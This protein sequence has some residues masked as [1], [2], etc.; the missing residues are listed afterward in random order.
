MISEFD[1]K[2]PEFGK[3]FIA[4][5]AQII[6]QVKIGNESSVWFNAT[7]RA[8]LGKI[9]IGS[10]VSIQDNCVLHTEENGTLEIADEVVVGHGAI[11][12]CSKIAS[13]TII[14]M[15]S[16]LLSGASIGKNCII[17]A[18]SVIPEGSIIPDNS[19]VMGVPG[20]VVRQSNDEDIKRIKKNIDQYVNLSK[21]YRNY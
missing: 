14:G 12:H 13:N 21:K 11:V 4:Q 10:K 8:D 16:I 1:K 15:G 3:V 7:I 6:G 2:K 20:K 19:I 17:A 5:N 9:V 18:G